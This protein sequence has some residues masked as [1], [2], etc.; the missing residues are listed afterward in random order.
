LL[1]AASF[2]RR[3]LSNKAVELAASAGDDGCCTTNP[4]AEELQH[5]IKHAI[6]NFMVSRK[7]LTMDANFPNFT[8]DY[9]L[10]RRVGKFIPIDGSPSSYGYRPSIPWWIRETRTVFSLFGRTMMSVFLI[11]ART[12]RK[13]ETD[14]YSTAAKGKTKTK[15]VRAHG[16]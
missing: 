9:M 12:E 1:R 8:V 5:A 6:V 16:L 7:W 3:R 15:T 10:A 2:C 13:P 11:A 14:S 4:K